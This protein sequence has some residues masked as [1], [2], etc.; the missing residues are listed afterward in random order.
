MYTETD[1]YPK[2][3][4]ITC[5]VLGNHDSGGRKSVRQ[6]AL[7]AVQLIKTA[8]TVYCKI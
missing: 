4:S 3:D 7:Y 8:S 5:P 6:M 1:G 2:H